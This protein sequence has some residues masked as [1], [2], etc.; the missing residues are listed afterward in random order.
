MFYV[1][2]LTLACYKKAKEK[3]KMKKASVV[4][5][6]VLMFMVSSCLV[7]LVCANGSD[8]VVTSDYHGKDVQLGTD[9]H[10]VATTTDSTVYQVTFIWHDAASIVR[11]GPE[12][13]SLSGTTT[14]AD[15]NS[16]FIFN[17]PVHAPNSVGDWGVQA[18]FQG[19]DGKTREGITE[20]VATRATSFNV[21]P[22]LPLIGTAG[23]SVAMVLG[24]ALFKAKRKPL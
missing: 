2:S 3:E 21:V 12:A 11:F 23:A 1:N 16:V 18:L 10:V 7:A 24:L 22:E 4:L 13:V 9:V 8:Y 19:P 5:L 17:A 14:D 15:G 20:V 6:L